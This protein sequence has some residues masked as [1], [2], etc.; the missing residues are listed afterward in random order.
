[1]YL[2]AYIDTGLGDRCSR[3]DQHPEAIGSVCRS[4]VSWVQG[5]RTSGRIPDQTVKQSAGTAERTHCI[6]RKGHIKL[7]EEDVCGA[8]LLS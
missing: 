7:R 4:G 5:S 6:K 3:R 1:V 2:V 8:T